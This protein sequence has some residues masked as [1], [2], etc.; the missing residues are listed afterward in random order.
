MPITTKSSHAQEA[1]DRGLT[2]AYSF[3][4]YAA[5]QEFRRAATLDPECAMAWW[6]VAL[7]NGPH[8]NFPTVP[9]EK[10]RTATEAVRKAQA[11]SEGATLLER[12]LIDALSKR[13]TYP[14]PENRA[15]LDEAYASAMR[16]LRAEFPKSADVATLFAESLMDQHPWDY[17]TSEGSQP[18]TPELLA[19][20][21]HALKLNARHP[22]A[23]HFYI[24]ALEASPGPE[25]AVSA[26]N[27]LRRLVPDSGHMVHMPSHIYARVGRWSDAAECNRQ[28]MKADLRYRAAFPRPGFYGI[29][30]AHNAHFLGFVAMMEGRSEEALWA[31]R[32]MV[33]GVPPDF[34]TEF[35]HVV[36][37]YTAFVPEVL[38]AIWSL[39]GDF[40]GTGAG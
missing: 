24:H 16:E 15:P 2:L 37:G 4:H 23:N 20:L 39:G 9:P 34:A 13:Y 12:R 18:W 19:N 36:D 29:Y 10:A 27:R 7:V 6:G 5:E 8:I 11:L 30:M 31:A 40:A 3:G 35:A 22:G 32:E 33:N 38:D 25:K 14:Q 17:W 21:E 26:A 28:A 1:F